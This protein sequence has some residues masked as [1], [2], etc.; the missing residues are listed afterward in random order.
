MNIHVL[1]HCFHIELLL[2]K[3]KNHNGNIGINKNKLNNYDT[4]LFEIYLGQIV[5]A[6]HLLLTLRVLMGYILISCNMDG[7]NFDTIN[8]M[9]C[10]LE[11]GDGSNYHVILD[12][13]F[14]D[15]NSI[16]CSLDKGI[17]YGTSITQVF[18]LFAYENGQNFSTA[19]ETNYN[20]YY[21]LPPKIVRLSN[22]FVYQIVWIL[23]IINWICIETIQTINVNI[24]H[25]IMPLPN[26]NSNIIILYC[27]LENISII[28]DSVFADQ[29]QGPENTHGI[30]KIQSRT[31]VS[32]VSFFSST[33]INDL[34]IRIEGTDIPY[35][36]YTDLHCKIGSMLF[37][38]TYCFRD[39]HI[40][41]DVIQYQLVDD[42][43]LV[44]NFKVTS[45]FQIKLPPIP[46]LK[47]VPS[48]RISD[49]IALS[50]KETN[51]IGS[52]NLAYKVTMLQSNSTDNGNS[53]INFNQTIEQFIEFTVLVGKDNIQNSNILIMNHVKVR[54]INTLERPNY[55]DI[56][57]FLS[58]ISNINTFLF[59]YQQIVSTVIGTRLESNKFWNI[60]R[61]PLYFL[62]QQLQDV[63]L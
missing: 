50:M 23:F 44:G 57:N 43:S 15:N 10:E 6:N 7:N 55:D 20:Y 37:D 58:V 16:I 47:N 9:S 29:T 42:N 24:L 1:I 49:E 11:P 38:V 53:N 8:N 63:Q 30:D 18:I 52:N 21:Y 51:F 27:M 5:Y 17:G 45:E 59:Y 46:T 33:D 14:I 32:N 56:I 61:A 12:V 22:S 3:H 31:N 54:T 60:S 35:N 62:M 48:K 28:I 41:K 25:S 2:F 36:L 34:Y 19:I 13:I 39:G 26:G 40:G 4:M